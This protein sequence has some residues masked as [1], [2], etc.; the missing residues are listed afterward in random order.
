MGD[1]TRVFFA[2]DVHGSDKCFRKFVNAAKFYDAH[3]LILGGD[4]TGKMVIPIVDVGNHSYTCTFLGN[5]LTLSSDQD[6]ANTV[7]NIRDAGYYPHIS[8]PDEVSE[9][10][11]DKT[12]VDILFE[13]LIV[14]SIDGWVKFAHE[15]LLNSN[16]KCYIS[17]GNDDTFAIDKHLP[18]TSVVINPE[19]RVVKID[20]MHE[21]ITLGYTNPTPW[22]TP[23]EVDE[24]KLEAMVEGMCSDVKDMKNC[25][26][27]LHCPPR[28]T[29]LDQAPALDS[30]LKPII[31]SGQFQFAPAGSLAVKK[32]VEKYQPLTGFHGHIHEA[33]GVET[34]GK[35][36]CFNPGS[37]YTEGI[38][39]G[40]LIDLED[41]KIKSYMFTSG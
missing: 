34:I 9:L 10:R 37:E 25:I 38:L 32:A 33:R 5:E 16:V 8:K 29:L 31:K 23:R 3:V 6:L 4:I 20:A 36:V 1:S 19:G 7:K 15:R 11:A 14:E 12:K 2:T 40:L 27:N 24:N 18:D 41:K 39:R 17:P 35:T 21:M 26:F 30:N 22:D 13:R 28:D